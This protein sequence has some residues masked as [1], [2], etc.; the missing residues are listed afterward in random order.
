MYGEKKE[1]YNVDNNHQTNIIYVFRHRILGIFSKEN[2]NKSLFFM[3][4][5][6]WPG[7]I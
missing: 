6:R 7:H 2:Q 4:V 5:K 3:G 1:R